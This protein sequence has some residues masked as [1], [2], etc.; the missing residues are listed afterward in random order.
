M[1][2][3]TKGRYALRVVVDIATHSQNN[4]I[5]L[6]EI[7]KRQDISTKYLEQ[8]MRLL[9]HANIVES[10]RGHLGGYK[11]VKSPAQIT[12]YDVLLASEGNLGCLKCVEDPLECDRHDQC[13]TIK[14]WVGLNEA[15]KD[16]LT[17]Y[18]IQDLIIENSNY[19]YII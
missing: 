6:K 12:T 5:S 10:T 2:I 16:Y 17:S 11:L 9:T 8:I 13:S 7:S 1:K 18:T 15:I 3:S 14:F 4:Y 19:N